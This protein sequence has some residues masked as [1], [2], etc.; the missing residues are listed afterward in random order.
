M[1]LETEILSFRYENWIS[2]QNEEL[3]IILQEYELNE[4]ESKIIREYR[5]ICLIS[6][7]PNVMAYLEFLKRD[8]D[9]M[10]EILN[11]ILSR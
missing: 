5:S 11:H 3:G 1:Q 6:Q 9:K 8:K 2:L 7:Y 4:M 10:I